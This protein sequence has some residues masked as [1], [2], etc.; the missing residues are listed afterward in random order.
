MVSNNINYDPN[1]NKHTVGGARAALAYVFRDFK[2]R[3][4]LDVGC[5]PG[6]WLRAALDLGIGDV[7]GVDGLELD[8]STLFVDNAIIQ[9]CN[10]TTPF[11]LNRS[12]DL[13]LCLEVG[14]HLEEAA[15]S[16]LIDSLT[17]HA[18]HILFSA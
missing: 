11:A 17:K 9:R 12:F 8:E 7:K 2:P 4:M 13:A 3:S 1:L 16:T 18:D 10:L 14:E 15:A 6:T 5:G